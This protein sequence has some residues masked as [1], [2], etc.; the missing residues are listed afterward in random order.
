MGIPDRGTLINGYR[1]KNKTKHTHTHTLRAESRKLD[2][3]NIAIE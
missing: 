2:R 1:G 3:V